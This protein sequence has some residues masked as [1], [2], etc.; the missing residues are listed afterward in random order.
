MFQNYW[1]FISFEAVLL[2]EKY[3]IA[4]MS[5]K[6]WYYCLCPSGFS[7]CLSSLRKQLHALRDLVGVLLGL[8]EIGR[9]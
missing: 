5:G 4:V 6:G 7:G 3:L 9:F 8:C 2:R 1:L